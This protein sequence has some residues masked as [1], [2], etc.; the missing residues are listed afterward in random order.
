[1]LNKA[2]LPLTLALLVVV[3]ACSK[4]AGPVEPPSADAEA[5]SA[6]ATAVESE[7]LVRKDIPSEDPGPPFYARVTSILDQFYHTDG[8]LAVPFYRSPSC[9]P[10]DFN[11]L[12]LFHFPGAGGPGAFGC[13]L[14]MSGFLLTEP[15]A[16]LGRF[17]R[18]VVLKG[19]G[20]PLWFVR[21]A[22]FQAA[23]ADGSVTIGELAGLDPLVGTTRRYHE[24]LKPREGDH[25]VV[26][27]ANGSL[28]DGRTFSFHV[29]HIED[30]THAIEIRFR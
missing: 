20:S 5:T 14:L 16:P 11:L 6:E 8:W 29:T 15:D 27:D 21:W 23:M 10:E 1:M 18:Q 7:G 25:L 13:P 17:P 12:D 2:S 22:D 19:S 9:V 30:E 24:T 4:E 26:I 3:A 28:D